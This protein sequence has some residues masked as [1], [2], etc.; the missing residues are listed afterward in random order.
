M[1]EFSDLIPQKNGQAAPQ[2]QQVSSN[3]FSDLIPKAEEHSAGTDFL[4]A[5]NNRVNSLASGALQGMAKLVSAVGVDTSNFQ[6]KLAASRAVYQKAGEEAALRSPKAAFAGEVL[7]DIANIGYASAATGG[8]GTTNAAPTLLGRATQQGALAGIESAAEYGTGEERLKRGAAGY[9]LGAAGQGALEGVGY[10]AKKGA[11]ALFNRPVAEAAQA[12]NEGQ[13]MTAGMATGNEGLQATEGYLAQLPLVG[14]KANY[15]NIAG[16]V[17]DQAQNFIEGQG[18]GIADNV[19]VTGVSRGALANSIVNET[20]AAEKLARAQAS[21]EYNVLKNMAGDTPIELNSAKAAA[22]E[23]L[24]PQALKEGFT[25][26]DIKN[27]EQGKLLSDIMTNGKASPQAFE[28]IRGDL[29]GYIKD[30]KNGAGDS[31]LLPV[32]T[33]VKAAMDA[34]LDAFGAKMGP[35]YQQQALKARQT[36]QDLVGPFKEKGSIL[37]RIIKGNST[38]DEILNAVTKANNPA[39]A[40]ELMSNLTPK[41][42]Q[43]FSQ[44]L[45]LNAAQKSFEPGA[46]TFSARRFGIA[47]N[48]MGETLTALPEEMQ[49]KIKGL[50]KVFSLADDVLKE[51]PKRRVFVPGVSASA[52]AAMFGASAAYVLAPLTKTLSFALTNPKMV[53]QLV[54]LGGGQLNE[55]VEKETVRQVLGAI[56]TGFKSAAL[57]AAASAG[58]RDIEESGYLQ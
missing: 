31:K 50:Q 8:L 23:A 40:K 11:S 25:Y 51:A 52:A 56:L 26:K 7:G 14:A 17:T 20:Q 54:R 24:N 1:D 15:K 36:Y 46:N 28:D 47:L 6:D 4:D 9:A 39:A 32:L 13:L 21:Q 2:P 22:E 42:Q 19:G 53:K 16:Q 43:D 37:N 12:L 5:F 18:I 41:G 38:P 35:E 33:K 45:I 58:G 57:P 29:G 34:D 48:K 44:A 27:S 3:E 30:I 55:T 10:L 49:T